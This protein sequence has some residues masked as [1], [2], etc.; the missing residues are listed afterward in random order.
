MTA[1]PQ[2]RQGPKVVAIGGGRGLTA[3]VRAACGYAA[4]TA[5]IVTTA[6]DSGS[7][8]RL[9]DSLGIPAPGDLRRCLVALAGAQD[10]VV[11]RAF[12][13]RF[14]DTDVAG[15]TLG[16]LVL[17]ALT[18]VTGD[19]VTATAETARLLGIDPAAGQ[20]LPATAV[21]VDLCAVTVE[22]KEV[23]GQYA[24][25]KTEGV[26]RV[27]LDPPDPASPDG[28]A[29]LILA[30]DQVVLGPG[31][32]FTSVLAAALVPRIHD[33]LAATPARRV[34]VCNLEPEDAE[35]RGH[36]VAAH[37]SALTAHGV[38]PDVVLVA[39]D[40][41]IPLGDLPA[42]PRPTLVRTPLALPSGDAHD[43]EKLA[44]ALAGLLP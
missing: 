6:D 27:A 3:T 31:S 5:A 29:E 24:I 38:H 10:A 11:G 2:R 4:H 8:G 13:H 25:S 12:E 35:T 37:L 44:A 17:A 22:G 21:P 18:T 43:S 20:V 9:R 39:D 7:T 36:D 23:R 33:A 1:I 30:A 26:D 42:G 28:A 41:P 34:Y 40:C 32:L 19:F 16:N 15:H 14:P